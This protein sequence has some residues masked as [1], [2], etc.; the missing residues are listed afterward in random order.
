MS[1]PENPDTQRPRWDWLAERPETVNNPEQPEQP[2]HD[3]D[4]RS[5]V[6]RVC[7]ATYLKEASG[8]I[9]ASIA[10]FGAMAAL[11]FIKQG[12]LGKK[13]TADYVQSFDQKDYLL[14]IPMQSYDS[15]YLPEITE[16]TFNS[17]PPYQQGDSF[18]SPRVYNF[19]L[20]GE[21]CKTFTLPTYSD[22]TTSVRLAVRQREQYKNG[23]Q[24][25]VIY[26]EK[27]L[28]ICRTNPEK[29]EKKDSSDTAH[30]AIAIQLP[31]PSTEAYGQP[32]N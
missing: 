5:S 23:S 10:V 30:M 1:T 2:T 13:I 6:A 17:I 28:S 8:Y 21:T 16:Q 14:D 26:G 4:S 24:F 12:N 7:H 25:G 19:K 27:T 31:S 3:I 15:I 32:I 11:G 20:G 18:T 22:N 9:A 29:Q